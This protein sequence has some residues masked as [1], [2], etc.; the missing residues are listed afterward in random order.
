MATSFLYVNYVNL[1]KRYV[2][3]LASKGAIFDTIENCIS[4]K[5]NAKKRNYEREKYHSNY[6]KFAVKNFIKETYL[7]SGYSSC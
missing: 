5:I 7:K 3:T 2:T 6:Q 1:L 4:D